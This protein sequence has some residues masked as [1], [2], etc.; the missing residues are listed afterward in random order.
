[1]FAEKD[2][3]KLTTKGSQRVA[4]SAKDRSFGVS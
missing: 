2:K 4:M 3:K 1:M